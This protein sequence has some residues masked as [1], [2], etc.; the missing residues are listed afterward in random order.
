[1]KKSQGERP[2]SKLDYKRHGGSIKKEKNENYDIGTPEN[3]MV[4]LD[5]TLDSHKMIGNDR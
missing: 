3:T 4:K 5:A 2:L 1:M